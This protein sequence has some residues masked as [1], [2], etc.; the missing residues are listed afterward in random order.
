MLRKHARSDKRMKKLSLFSSMT[1]NSIT[2]TLCRFSNLRQSVCRAERMNVS[3]T[4][5]RMSSEDK[6]KKTL[7]DC[8]SNHQ[9]RPQMIHL[10]APCITQ[11]WFDIKAS[12]PIMST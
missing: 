3:P 7:C 10:K 9:N 8:D 5:W 11:M 6:K 1:S 12:N 4:I 2:S